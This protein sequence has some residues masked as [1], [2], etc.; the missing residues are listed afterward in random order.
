[1]QSIAGS[2]CNL[3]CKQFWNAEMWCNSLSYAEFVLFIL[4]IY[5]KA[6]I[7]KLFRCEALLIASLT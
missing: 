1:M 7:F 2:V 6:L 5:H 3:L 4:Q